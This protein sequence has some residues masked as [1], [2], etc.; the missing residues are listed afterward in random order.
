M[1][2]ILI[3][4]GFNIELGGT[5]YL[6]GAIINRFIKNVKTKDYAALLFTITLLAI[7]NLLVFFWMDCMK[8]SKNTKW[9]I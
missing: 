1:K 3:G 2:T 9:S 7:M 6:N 5:D 4:N 8:N